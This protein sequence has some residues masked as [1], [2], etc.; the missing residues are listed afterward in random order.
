MELDFNRELELAASEVEQSSIVMPSLNSK[1]HSAKELFSNVDFQQFMQHG[2]PTFL[3]DANNLCLQNGKLGQECGKRRERG[4][5]YLLSRYLGESG[6][7]CP[8]N[9]H[10]VNV[11]EKGKDFYLFDE[12]VSIKTVSYGSNGFNQLKISWIEDKLI[13]NDFENN[14]KP[15]YDLLLCRIKWDSDDE[16]IYYINKDIQIEVLQGGN[17]FKTAAGY[18]KGTSLT[19]EACELLVNH[20][21]TLKLKINMPKEYRNESF[22]SQ[23]FDKRYLEIYSNYVSND[24]ELAT[25]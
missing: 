6:D 5:L 1:F 16:G 2:W 12:A 24:C 8:V 22:L 25:I 15:E 20:P 3:G 17:I 19:T 21:D 7:C 13:A 4:L 23:L 14:W 10:D 11:V 18:S 9:D